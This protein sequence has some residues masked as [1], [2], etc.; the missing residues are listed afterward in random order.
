MKILLS[1]TLLSLT[2]VC[3]FLTSSSKQDKEKRN[4][5]PIASEVVS[6]PQFTHEM[7]Q[8]ILR[9][10]SLGTNFVTNFLFCLYEGR[11]MKTPCLPT[12]TLNMLFDSS[13]CSCYLL[14]NK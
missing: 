3:A 4:V 1:L 9:A 12:L 7:I 10:E 2:N 6:N 5:T 13:E 14:H 11:E 8:F